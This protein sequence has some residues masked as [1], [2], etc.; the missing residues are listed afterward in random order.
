MTRIEPKQNTT[1]QNRG[2]HP[3]IK[4]GLSRTEK[5]NNIVTDILPMAIGLGLKLAETTGKESKP[6]KVTEGDSNT[7]NPKKTTKGR[8]TPETSG[9]STTLATAA[10]TSEWSSILGGIMGAADIAIN[11]GRSTPAKGAASGTAVGAAIG[12]M[13]APGPGTAIGAAIGALAGGL[14]GSIKTGK[15]AD[16]K[17]RDQVRSFL[18]ERGVIDN[19][20]AIGLAD[21]SRFNIGYDG[22]PKSALGGRRPFE[23]DMSNPLTKYAISWLNPVVAFFSQGN[24]KVQSDFVGYLANAAISNAKSIEDLKANVNSIIKQFGLDDKTIA[25]GISDAVKSGAIDKDIGAAWLN[26]IKERTSSRFKGEEQTTETKDVD[27]STKTDEVD[28]E[29]P[30]EQDEEQFVEEA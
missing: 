28:S 30:I 13:I 14:L 7:A 20:Y 3:E 8:L 11:W 17:V 10:A 29:E 26:G 18:Q 9:S 16:Q 24:Q 15:H 12:T 25:G 27:D 1:E 19:N 21:G 23:T 5:A 2:Y 6:R 4:G 22:G